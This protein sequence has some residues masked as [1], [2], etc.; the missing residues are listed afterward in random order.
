MVT[1][2]TE[3]VA[4][5]MA[6][7]EALFRSPDSLGDCSFEDATVSLASEFDLGDPIVKHLAQLVQA[8]SAG[9]H[10]EAMSA[11]RRVR[12]R[13]TQITRQEAAS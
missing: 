5:A 1:V 7:V 11:L 6:D 9:R 12:D 8:E 3:R 13:V 10:R 4:E 2:D